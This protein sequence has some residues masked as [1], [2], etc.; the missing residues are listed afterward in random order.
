MENNDRRQRQ[1]TSGYA[2]QQGL[3][4]PQSQYP[5]VS[6]SDRYRPPLTTQAPASAP[7]S[8]SRANPQSYAYAYGEGSQLLGAAIPP[9]GVAYTADYAPEQQRTSQSYSQYGQNVMYNVSSQQAAAPQSPYESVQP[10]QRQNASHNTAAIEVL[11][12]QFGVPQSYYV[13]GESAGPTSA[14]ATAMSAQNVPTQYSSLGYQP[15]QSP[16]GRDTLAP[17]YTAGM[18]DPSQT[19]SQGGFPQPGYAQQGSSANEEAYATYQTQLKKVN[20][21]V[22]DSRIKEA[23]ELVLSMSEWLLANAAAYGKL[24]SQDLWN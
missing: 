14:P 4:Q 22:R 19:A 24:S 18:S 9:A 5:V 21:Y 3:I 15:G 1:S 6:A 8:G 23:G 20:E 11:S 2:G 12:N 16:V 17:S 7:S 10:Y 13:A